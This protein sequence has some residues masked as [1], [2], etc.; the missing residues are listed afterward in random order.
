MF[1]KISLQK[2]SLSRFWR[3]EN[4][5]DIY[6]I[7]SILYSIKLSNYFTVFNYIG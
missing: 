7:L 6:S 1:I 3:R 2:E 5:S 4:V